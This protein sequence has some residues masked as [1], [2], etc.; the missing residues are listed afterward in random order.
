VVVMSYHGLS[1]YALVLSGGALYKL[2]LFLRTTR[3]KLGYGIILNIYLIKKKK[4]YI[5]LVKFVMN[6]KN[7]DFKYYRKLEE[8]YSDYVIDIFFSRRNIFEGEAT[9]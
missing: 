7:L 2:H 6:S 5:L 9:T 1:N 3:I 4:W 8:V